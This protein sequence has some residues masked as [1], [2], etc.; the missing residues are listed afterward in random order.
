MILQSENHRPMIGSDRLAAS[1]VSDE[2]YPVEAVRAYRNKDT[3]GT[4]IDD[5]KNS[6]DMKRMRM[7]TLVNADG[8]LFVQFI[9]LILISAICKEMRTC[10]THR[11]LSMRELLQEMKAGLNTRGGAMPPT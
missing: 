7:H 2:K 1:A 9:A 11:E 3:V 5:L 4:C 8:R 6:L 10:E